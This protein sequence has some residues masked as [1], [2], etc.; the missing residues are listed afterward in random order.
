MSDISIIVCTYNRSESLRETLGAL[1]RQ[2]VSD[3]VRLD[4]VVVD[5]NSTDHTRTVVEE[6]R[7]GSVWPIR[8]TFES[9]QGV[10]F[11]RN[12]GVQEAKG[13]IVA[14][15]DDDVLP[16]PTWVHT[17]A[18]AFTIHHADGVGGKILPLWL[19]PPPPWLLDERVRRTYWCLLALLDHGPDVIVAHTFDGNLIYGAN[20]AFRK[21]V[22]DEVGF[23]RTDVGAIGSQLLRGDETEMLQRLVAAGKRLVYT[24]HAVVH[25][26]VPPE[27][28]RLPYAR[29]WRF[30]AGHSSAPTSPKGACIPMW[31]VRECAENGLGALW[32]H[33]RRHT[34]C[35]I[36]RELQF[37]TQL[38]QIVGAFRA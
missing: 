4:I 18:E 3:G 36:E 38:G 15:V 26:K 7:K 19:Q 28:M 25:H 17:I 20:M 30:W 37:W 9:R 29:W 11:A 23:F 5:N 24:P 31:L 2:T 35:A 12:R 32:A 13:E 14:F 10:N 21:R 33:G 8:Y 34:A 6:I 16:E 1:G 22:F 27:R